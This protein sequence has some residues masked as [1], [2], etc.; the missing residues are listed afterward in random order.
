MNDFSDVRFFKPKKSWAKRM[1]KAWKKTIKRAGEVM[2]GRTAGVK[3]V[4]RQLGNVAK[5]GVGAAG[6]FLTGGPV[7]AVAGAYGG[8]RAAKQHGGI[9][10]SWTPVFQGIGAGLGAGAATSALGL[11]SG[12][13]GGGLY[14]GVSTLF[15]GGAGGVAETTQQTATKTNLLQKVLSGEASWTDV[16]GQL[17][18]AGISV[19]SEWLSKAPERRELEQELGHIQNYTAQQQALANKG[20]GISEARANE[21]YQRQMDELRRSQHVQNLAT[22]E[23][24]AERGITPTTGSSI[25]ASTWRGV[26]EEQQAATTGREILRQRTLENIGLQR[27][28][29][30][31]SGGEEAYRTEQAYESTYPDWQKILKS[32]VTPSAIYGAGEQVLSNIF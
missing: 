13:L 30:A 6:G 15:G 14:R 7:G 22:R 19:A 9:G 18:D 5:I 3:G 29:A 25:G 8:Y 31:L 2:K 17:K 27:E 32:R 1:K 12:G 26:G 10:G 28:G 21:D 23:S 24:L 11:G 4:Q 20:Y 16:L